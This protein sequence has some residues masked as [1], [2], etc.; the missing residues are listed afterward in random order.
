MRLLLPSILQPPHPRHHPPLL[1][2]LL[3]TLL[4]PSRTYASALALA[5]DNI[6][7]VTI[8]SISTAT[9][10]TIETA[11]ATPVVPQDPSYTSPQQ[12]K[13]SI[14]K[15]TNA[16]RAAYNASALTW[17]DTLA[18]F[19]KSWAGGC[20]WEHSG[21]P[22]GEN[23]AYGY[24]NVSSSITAWAEEASLYDFHKPTGFSEETGHFTQLVWKSTRQV[25]CGAVDCGVTSLEGAS[26]NGRAQ[27]WFLVCEYF[28]GGNV[29]GRRDK[30]EL[31]RGN[32]QENVVDL[33][34]LD[35][36]GDGEGDGEETDS[37]S[38]NDESGSRRVLRWSI[39]EIGWWVGLIM[40]IMSSTL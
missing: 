26:G 2:L 4:L 37:E 13:S 8:S 40:C 31:F 28:P 33:G 15:T 24:V 14:L 7:I 34:D 19:A 18:D 9:A 21:A 16:Y 12:F 1:T 29:V 35:G 39:R 5:Q 22:Y 3:T 11:T 25:G 10:T 6:V 23:L 32:V 27:G 30:N 17:N 20:N 36:D 38:E